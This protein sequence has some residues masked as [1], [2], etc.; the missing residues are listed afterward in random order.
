M[1]QAVARWLVG[2]VLEL[3]LAAPAPAADQSGASPQAGPGGQ[4]LV[5]GQDR[6][7]AAIPNID[8]QRLRA[9]ME[10]SNRSVRQERLYQF[11]RQHRLH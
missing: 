1:A 8:H 6:S 4:A 10:A 5:P 3:F 11:M 7:A 2:V 9:A